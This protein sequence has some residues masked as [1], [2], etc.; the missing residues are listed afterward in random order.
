[1]QLRKTIVFTEQNLESFEGDVD[2]GGK[3]ERRVKRTINK[4]ESQIHHKAQIELRQEEEKAKNDANRK[5]KKSRDNES[6]IQEEDEDISSD[7]ACSE[8]S[9]S[10]SSAGRT[11]IN[12][13]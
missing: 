10:N 2:A 5:K 7:L 4:R 1:M 3:I 9:V 6:A 8:D 11:F 13:K 12:Y